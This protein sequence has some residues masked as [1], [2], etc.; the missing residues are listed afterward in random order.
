MKRLE[1]AVIAILSVMLVVAAMTMLDETVRAHVHALLN[2]DFSMVRAYA[3]SGFHD[4]TRAFH[5]FAYQANGYKSLSVFA[6][7]A[8]VLVLFMRK[9]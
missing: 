3:G 2:G 6:I 7:G 5:T 1:A 8:S 9:L 4:G